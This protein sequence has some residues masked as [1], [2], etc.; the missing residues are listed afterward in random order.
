MVKG[1]TAVEILDDFREG[2]TFQ[3]LVELYVYDK[4]LKI[5]MLDVLERIEIALRANITLQLGQYSPWAYREGDF[6][7][8][9]FVNKIH[10]GKTESVYTT[11]IDRFDSM[12]V[13]S[14]SE[15]VEHF[16]NKY[17]SHLPIWAAV[18]LWDFGMLS[19]FYSGLKYKDQIAIANIYGLQKK[20]EVLA[21][22]IRTLADVRN[23]CAH[24]GRLWN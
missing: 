17:S 18:E 2:S 22:W 19:K 4:R 7:N 15:S 6:L 3:S 14:K 23:I 20:P 10:P 11:L 12:V 16:R 5:L 21:S 8:Q 13:N 1:G 9:G 24:H